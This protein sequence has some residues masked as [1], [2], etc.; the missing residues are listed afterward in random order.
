VENYCEQRS[1]ELLGPVYHLPP[2]CSL[3]NSACMCDYRTRQ[4]ATLFVVGVSGEDVNDI[5]ICCRRTAH[6]GNAEGVRKEK[7]HYQPSGYFWARIPG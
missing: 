6:N 1:T 4:R 5:L 3:T 2:P 7:S